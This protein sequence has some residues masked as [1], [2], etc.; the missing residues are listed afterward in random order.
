MCRNPGVLTYDWT[1]NGGQVMPDG[2]KNAWQ[3]GSPEFKSLQ[4][5]KLFPLHMAPLLLQ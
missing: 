1:K 2:V 5:K 4:M 3:I